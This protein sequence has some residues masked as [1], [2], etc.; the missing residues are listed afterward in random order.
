MDRNKERGWWPLLME[1]WVLFNKKNT[2]L[3]TNII[4][5]IICDDYD[6]VWVS[7]ER[8]NSFLMMVKIGKKQKIKNQKELITNLFIDSFDNKW[9]CTP[10]NIIVYN[11]EGV[12]FK[13]NNHK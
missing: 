2:P 3:K 10:K 8:V 6:R 1:G 7:T 11:L 12:E 13:N 9:I 5:S 4:K